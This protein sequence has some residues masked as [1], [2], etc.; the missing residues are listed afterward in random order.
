M[1]IAHA[2]SVVLASLFFSNVGNAIQVAA[3]ETNS[4]KPGLVAWHAS[5]EEARAAAQLS[6]RPVL[7]FQLLGRLDEEFC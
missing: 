6:R 3:L 4:V 2:L 5:F 7:L 1:K